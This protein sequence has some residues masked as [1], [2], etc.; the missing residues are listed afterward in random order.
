MSQDPQEP[1]IRKCAGPRDGE[2][3]THP[4]YGMIGIA[5]IQGHFKLHG[6]ALESHGACIRLEIQT[7]ERNTHLEQDWHHARQS[8]I[9]VYLSQ[10]Q[11]AEFIT[12]PNIG[13]GVP[14][15]IARINNVGV[16]SI[17]MTTKTEAGKVMDSF[18]DDQVEIIRKL[19]IKLDE[20]N[21][22]LDKKGAI[23][24]GD[25]AV[26]RKLL[27]YIFQEVQANRPFV[28]KQFQ[29]AAEKVVVA[30]KAEVEA[31]TTMALH[32]LGLSKLHELYALSTPKKVRRK[33]ISEGDKDG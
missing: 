5:R 33:A 13:D 23:N 21:A 7:A 24:K 25:R 27:E 4:A 1:T 22:I 14:C 2:V 11:F 9:T 32:K 26:I 28:L 8:L 6:S 31:F 30:S 3:E 18:K 12:T 17:A 19:R 16:P 15:T 29:R 10:A 20:A